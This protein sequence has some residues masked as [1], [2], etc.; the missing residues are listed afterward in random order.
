MAINYETEPVLNGEEIN[1]YSHEGY[2]FM[3][4]VLSIFGGSEEDWTVER[5]IF[6]HDQWDRMKTD[7]CHRGPIY[8]EDVAAYI[9]SKAND[10]GYIPSKERGVTQFDMMINSVREFDTRQIESLG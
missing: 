3:H 9:E 2:L 8:P 1:P 10:I 7:L 6:I 5:A 4:K